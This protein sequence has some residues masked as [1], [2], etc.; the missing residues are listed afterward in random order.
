MTLQQ[1][2]SY[3]RHCL[4]RDIGKHKTSGIADFKIPAPIP[5]S[6]ITPPLLQKYHLPPS[7]ASVASYGTPTISALQ[8]NGEAHTTSTVTTK[9]HNH[10]TNMR[11]AAVPSQD[12]V[13]YLFCSTPL[14]GHTSNT[15]KRPAP[16]SS[17]PS[18]VT[19]MNSTASKKGSHSTSQPTIVSDTGSESSSLSAS[20]CSSDLIAHYV[21][22]KA[23]IN[24]SSDQILSSNSTATE[25]VKDTIVPCHVRRGSRLKRFKLRACNTNSCHEK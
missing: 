25:D 21:P 9:E 24:S 14:N 7:E 2:D 1:Y 18:I 22:L 8:H 5:S 10:K 11:S 19:S 13:N 4:S 16:H 6:D 3:W 12:Y 15:K 23:S 17:A 20:S